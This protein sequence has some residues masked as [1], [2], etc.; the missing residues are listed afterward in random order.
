MTTNISKIKREQL[1]EKISVLRGY[2][3]RCPQ[4]ENTENLLQYISEIEKDIK[5]KKYGLVFEEHREALD[6]TLETHLPVLTEEESLLIDNGGQMNF[7][8]EG[9]NLASL[10]LL[11]KTHAGKV[12]VIYIDPPYNTGAK[13][14]KYNN[15]YVDGNDT[16]RHSKWLSMM[17]PRLNI[18][19]QLLTDRG[20]LVCAIDHYELSTIC[21]L[22]DGIFGEENRLGIVSVVHKPEGRNQEKFFATSNEFA[23]FY[24][25]DIKRCSFQKVILTEE[26]QSEFSMQDAIGR[27]KLEP[28]IAKNHGRG[29]DDKNL[30]INRP[31]KYY[32]IYVTQDGE[33][34]LD[35]SDNCTAIYPKSQ[36]TERT[37]KYTKEIMLSKIASG[38][39]VAQASSKTYKLYEKYRESKGE[40]IKTHWIKKEYNANFGGTK[41]LNEILGSVGGF[42]FPKS[43]YLIEDTLK[44]TSRK[45]STIVDFFAGSG[46]TGHAV[47]KLNKED[48][49]QRKFILCTNNENGICRNVTY[50]RIKRVIE[51][52]NYEA[53]LKYMR[54]DYVPISEQV[55]YEYADELLSHVRELVELEN[56]INFRGNSEIAIVL[57][58]EELSAFVSS[59]AVQGCKTLYLGH[60]VAPDDEA[61]ETLSRHGVKVN[62]I[63]EY[64]YSEMEG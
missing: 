26:K 41:V 31:H 11:E 15:D 6:E 43:L 59:D 39:I 56:G 63:P 57:T 60:D 14:W 10:K 45:N 27:Y 35:E 5:G 32:P 9:D 28:L 34:S 13:D 23:L 12:D 24:A 53:S 3:E 48:R 25:K 21:M 58:D 40:L 46:T 33:I 54:V 38:E 1:A 47:L 20:I 30:R 18:A 8:I 4:D 52:E 36:S 19:K 51:K 49:G 22:L 64:Y 42:D 62:I 2:I 55:Y 37:W 44:I 61:I 7:L 50:E 17:N 29:G 16:F